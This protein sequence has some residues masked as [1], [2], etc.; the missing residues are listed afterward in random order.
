MLRQVTSLTLL[1]VGTF[2]LLG[3]AANRA[4]LTSPAQGGPTWTEF[5][6]AHFTVF[7]D[8]DVEEARIRLAHFEQLYEALE[9]LLQPP[10]DATPTPLRVVVFDRDKDFAALVGPDHN[11]GAYHKRGSV[12]EL[13]PSS[14][15]VMH[16]ADLD[17]E[18]QEVFLHELTHQFLALRF[19]PLPTWL[20]EGLAQYYETLR[21]EGNQISLGAPG[22]HDFSEQPHIWTSWRGNL[23]QTQIPATWAPTVWDLVHSDRGSFYGLSS[24]PE[25]PEEL[26]KRS[27]THY[28]AAWK[29]VHL[30][31]NGPDATYRSRFDAMLGALQAGTR[32][33]E[34]FLEQY[35]GDLPRLQADYQ[36][37]LTQ[38]RLSR[39]HATL[40]PPKPR[41]PAAQRVLEEAE[42]HL[43]WAHAVYS[44]SKE[45]MQLY[46]QRL[47]AALAAS[48]D[49]PETALRRGIFFFH[50]DQFDEAEREIARGLKARPEHPDLIMATLLIQD[51]R[52]TDAKTGGP[53][54]E[55]SELVARLARTATSGVQLALAGFFMGRQGQVEEGLRM[56]ERAVAKAPL[57]YSCKRYQAALLASLGRYDEALAAMERAL[58]ISPESAGMKDLMQQRAQILDQKER[59]A[60]KPAAPAAAPD[61]QAPTSTP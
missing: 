14:T 44:D 56:V 15:L 48:P 51:G 50:Q 21:I 54:A 47:D 5:R 41:A 40:P 17:D 42:V 43:V 24:R 10:A 52:P 1:V 46:R 61:A 36:R 19:G 33:R 9:H 27:V 7:T 4:P 3:C 28:T 12:L 60:T 2:F 58:G 38:A 53:S 55:S 8:L 20:N 25:K 29:F 23:I 31:S 22:A 45:A 57:C 35:G 13:D 30:L 11:V 16:G 37:Y 39:R 34:A 6:S 26:Q 32:P 49:H 59:A 18:T